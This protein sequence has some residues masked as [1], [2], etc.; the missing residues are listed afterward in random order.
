MAR[1]HGAAVALEEL[2]VGQAVQARAGPGEAG[3]DAADHRTRG[4]R[5]RAVLVKQV[6]QAVG[7][8]AVVAQEQDRV[9]G[10]LARLQ[11]GAQG[12]HVAAA[13]G[14][15]GGREVDDGARLVGQP[16]RGLVA[17]DARLGQVHVAK[18][19][20]G[21]FRRGLD[22][23]LDRRQHR[24]ALGAA[25]AQAR[26][27]GI[28]QVGLLVQADGVAPEQ[29]RALGQVVDQGGGGP[30]P[31]QVALDAVVE[32]A[33]LE[34][35]L[36]VLER[37]LVGSL[38]PRGQFLLG[39]RQA[40]QAGV[41]VQPQ[42]ADR[43]DDRLLGALDRALRLD[44]E[45]AQRD[46]LVVEELDAQRPVARGEHVEQAAAPREVA[47][48]G[49]HAG[50][51]VTAARQQDAQLVRVD[52]VPGA[53]PDD[54]VLKR[55]RRHDAL[56]QCRQRGHGQD[57]GL[58]AQAMQPGQVVAGGGRIRRVAVE[59][60]HLWL[61]QVAHG[62]GPEPDLEVVGEAVGGFAV[63]GDDEGGTPA[64]RVPGGEHEAGGAAAQARHQQRPVAGR[65]QGGPQRSDGRLEALARHLVQQGGVQQ[66]AR[67]AARRVRGV[68]HDPYRAASLTGAAA[69]AAQKVARCSL[70]GVI[71]RRRS[72]MR[73]STSMT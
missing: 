47:D 14:L 65:L 66:P 10:R 12:G 1:A 59:G 31:R 62:A 33:V 68:G 63:G 54:G 24:I 55:A 53:Q 36:Q 30:R 70:N 43:D 67:A 16:A 4:E 52:A 56:A 2:V 6:G 45:Q 48:L 15:R 39:A 9:A 49:D 5:R 37:V 38:G 41:V 44:L 19:A 73:G 7:L 21:Q 46:D 8:S 42:V 20:R 22:Q 61:R 26:Q 35:A 17:R 32:Q 60:Q 50:R 34:P 69:P 28:Q 25:L 29:R 72:M 58:G 11:L 64:G 27:L 3:G 13:Q 23:F 18:P 57:A 40:G 51:A 71:R